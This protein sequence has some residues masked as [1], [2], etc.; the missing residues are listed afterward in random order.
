MALIGI[1][2][3][4]VLFLLTTCLHFFTS[5][6]Q[7]LF[8]C[9]FA[10]DVYMKKGECSIEVECS[11]IKESSGMAHSLCICFFSQN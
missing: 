11:I 5:K 3:H 10:R 6:T 9:V 4:L 2:Y 7:V 8:P 1:I